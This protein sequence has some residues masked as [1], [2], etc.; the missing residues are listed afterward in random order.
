MNETSFKNIFKRLCILKTI[1]FVTKKAKNAPLYH[2]HRYNK[3]LSV[4]SQSLSDLVKAL[5]GLVVMSSELELMS[6][7]LFINAVPEI[8]KAKARISQMLTM[9]DIHR[10]CGMIVF[11]AMYRLCKR[12]CACN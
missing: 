12:S 1:H 5:K 10:I 8:W 9:Q 6:N 2:S 4:I 11:V 3:L 7:S